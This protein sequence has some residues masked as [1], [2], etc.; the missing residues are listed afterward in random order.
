MQ[1]N[2]GASVILTQPAF[3]LDALDSW[4]VDAERKGLTSA[5][6]IL[7]GMPFISSPGNLA[8]WLALASCTGNPAS[9]KL[10]GEIQ[11]A[12]AESKSQL[13]SFCRQYNRNL[14]ARLLRSPG[15]SGLHVMPITPVAKQMVLESLGDLR[16][17]NFRGSVG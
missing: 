10:L 2:Q 3:D 15:V 16:Y 5:A 4:L 11:R 17:D 8:F 7:I 1:V 14:A 12:A 13:A 6:K 9:Q